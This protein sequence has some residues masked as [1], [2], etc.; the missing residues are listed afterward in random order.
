LG[1]GCHSRWC[2][3][4]AIHTTPD[5]VPGEPD[6]DDDQSILLADTSTHQPL[7]QNDELFAVE[8]EDA[9]DADEVVATRQEDWDDDGHDN[10]AERYGDRDILMGNLNARRSFVDVAD[11]EEDHLRN[12]RTTPARRSSLGAKA[13]VILGIQ[14]IFIVIPQ[15]LVTGMTSL[16]FAI[17]EPQKSVLHGNHPGKTPP[18]LNIST[19]TTDNSTLVSLRQEVGANGPPSGPNSVAVIFRI[20]GIWAIIAFV[21]TWRL[22][23]ELQRHY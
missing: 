21:L 22:T 17:L 14:N 16:I 19:T 10:E 1:N 18:N 13:G 9:D 11:F 12:G 3:A 8:G 4:E 7:P 5:T 23:K 2:I 20:G 6:F 15:F